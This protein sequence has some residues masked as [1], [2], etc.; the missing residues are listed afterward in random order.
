M[1][2]KRIGNVCG[3]LAF[4]W[5]LQFFIYLHFHGHDSEISYPI[6][7]LRGGWIV[8]ILLSAAGGLFGRKLWWALTL[9][10]VAFGFSYR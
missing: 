10:L 3:L 5:C 1:L 4:L 6:M 9:F 8:A 7:L 2:R